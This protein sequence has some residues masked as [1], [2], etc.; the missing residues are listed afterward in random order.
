M[1]KSEFKFV[2][3]KSFR[4]PH[5]EDDYEV[6]WQFHG[7]QARKDSDGSGSPPKLD[8]VPYTHPGIKETDQHLVPSDVM[9][10]PNH[11]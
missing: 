11:G 1:K 2:L 4:R 5:L 3:H 6:I 7:V 10:P 9:N 8:H